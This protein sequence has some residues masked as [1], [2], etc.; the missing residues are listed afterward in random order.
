MA[1]TMKGLRFVMYLF[2]RYYS[3]G[4][5]KRIPYFS[6]LCA[7]VFLIYIHI[8]QILI[9]LDKVDFSPIKNDDVKIVNYGKIAVFLLPFFLIISYLVRPKDLQNLS[10]T[11]AQIRK[12][13]TFLVV[14]VIL[15][16]TL[17]FVLM[18]AFAKT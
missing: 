4:G 12:G 18:F 1:I 9:V 11:E 14:Y 17:L 8:F 7:V 5:T 6:T 2:Y 3:R 13:N 15:S 16:V 10:Y